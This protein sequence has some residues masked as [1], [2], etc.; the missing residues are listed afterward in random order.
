MGSYPSGEG[1][2]RITY[3]VVESLCCTPETNAALCVNYTSINQQQWLKKKKKEAENR[4]N[5][6]FIQYFRKRYEDL[7]KLAPNVQEKL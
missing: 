6:T 5:V 1:E 4:V 7:K 3:R 2:H